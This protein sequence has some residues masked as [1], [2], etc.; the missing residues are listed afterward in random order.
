[1]LFVCLQTFD[2][3]D[4]NVPYR[5][6]RELFLNTGSI[7][8]APHVSHHAGACGTRSRQAT[9]S[10]KEGAIHGVEPDTSSGS[11][12]QVG[13]IGEAGYWGGEVSFE[14]STVR[15]LFK[16]WNRSV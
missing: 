12:A 7:D 13:C 6:I 1:M 8:S 4:H 9:T 5:S 2:N 3:N 14:P 10:E 16:Y 11:A 15:V